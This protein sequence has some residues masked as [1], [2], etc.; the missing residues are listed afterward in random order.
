[1][2]CVFC[3]PVALNSGRLIRF[4]RGTARRNLTLQPPSITP[5]LFI[6]NHHL[7]AHF[8][9]SP[10]I[11]SCGNLLLHECVVPPFGL[12]LSRSCE[13]S[14]HAD[15]PGRP[16]S[17]RLGLKSGEECDTKRSV[18]RQIFQG[19]HLSSA[20][21]SRTLLYGPEGRH[22]RQVGRVQGGHCSVPFRYDIPC[23]C[24]LRYTGFHNPTSVFFK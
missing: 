16:E 23:C 14:N 18:D 19:S 9:S 22:R 15:R 13:S 2:F 11:T 6:I 3:S 17:H 5:Y 21:R 8:I 12:A 7:N 1:M 20:T 10:T 4:W 24:Y